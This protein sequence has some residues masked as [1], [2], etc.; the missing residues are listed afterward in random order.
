[1]RRLIFADFSGVVKPLPATMW[2]SQELGA[3]GAMER[4]VYL[5]I[6]NARESARQSLPFIVL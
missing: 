4:R 5:S 1:M 2:K 3:Q 6:T